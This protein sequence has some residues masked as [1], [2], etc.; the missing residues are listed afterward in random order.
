MLWWDYFHMTPLD[1]YAALTLTTSKNVSS[2][3]CDAATCCLSKALNPGK[4]LHDKIQFKIYHQNGSRRNQWSA[5][6]K[7]SSTTRMDMNASYRISNNFLEFQLLFQIPQRVLKHLLRCWDSGRRT[8]GG[9]LNMRLPNPYTSCIV[10]TEQK[11]TIDVKNHAV[12]VTFMTHELMFHNVPQTG[13]IF[14]FGPVIGK[15]QVNLPK[16]LVFCMSFVFFA[17]VF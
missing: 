9:F 11:L 16:P 12:D 6:N 17:W 1:H 8:R 4:R 15:T 14:L 5:L 13:I 3:R 2:A 7:K 10:T